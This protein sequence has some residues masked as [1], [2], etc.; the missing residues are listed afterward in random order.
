MTEG[1]SGV[2]SES[3]LLQSQAEYVKHSL[4]LRF[5]CFNAAM[6]QRRHAICPEIHEYNSARIYFPVTHR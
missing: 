5:L 1:F 4:L 6:R 3:G 2:E